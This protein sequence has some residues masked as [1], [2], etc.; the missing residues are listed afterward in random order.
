MPEWYLPDRNAPLSEA[1]HAEFFAMWRE[2]LKKPLA[3]PKTWVIR[4]Y[5]LRG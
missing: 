1:K 3:A 4:D 5:L 2:L